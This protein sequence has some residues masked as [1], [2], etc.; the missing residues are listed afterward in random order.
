MGLDIE[1]PPQSTP[2]QSKNPTNGFE[3]LCN[4]YA[5]AIATQ[6]EIREAI[7]NGMKPLPTKGKKAPALDTEK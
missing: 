6:E 1:F 2:K 7:A 4:A 5:Y 3:S